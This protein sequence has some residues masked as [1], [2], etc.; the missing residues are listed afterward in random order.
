MADLIPLVPPHESQ[1]RT[2]GSADSET[3]CAVMVNPAASLTALMAATQSRAAL[4]YAQLDEWTCAPPG[5]DTTAEK[6]AT[7]LAPTAYELQALMEV[8]RLKVAALEGPR[9]G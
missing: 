9:H 5:T 6:L 4:L 2:G 1:H 7:F 8:M 3:D